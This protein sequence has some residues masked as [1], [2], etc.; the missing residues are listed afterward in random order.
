MWKRS[1]NGTVAAPGEGPTFDHTTYSSRGGYIYLSSA[2]G[3]VPNSVARFIT[4]LLQEAS[5]T[6]MLELWLYITGTASDQ[7]RVTLL[8]GNQIERATLERFHYRSMSNWTK[9]TI[10]I[11]RIDVPFQLAIDSARTTNFGW[12]AID[13]T[14]I[15]RC[16]MP[17]IVAA[18]QC[19]GVNQFQCARGSC[20][21]KSRICDLTD[22]CGDHSDESSRL[23][24][25]YQ[26]CTFDISFCDWRQDNTTEFQ[27]ELVKGPSPS[28]ETGVCFSHLMI[29]ESLKTIVL[30]RLLLLA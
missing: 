23:C 3:T 30:P 29:G 20:I 21:A 2:N 15:L 25:S 5:S 8:T 19:Q 9:V 27:W 14:R 13:D 24:S 11:G 12:T 6:C 1:T 28:D 4:P 26:T 22:D 10:E 16:Q 7:L 17:P 18:A